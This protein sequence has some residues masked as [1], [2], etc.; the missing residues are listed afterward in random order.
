MTSIAL[1]NGERLVSAWAE[2][3]NGPGWSNR[4]VWYVVMKADQTYDMRAI[5][6]QDQTLRMSTLCNVSDVVT[7]DMTQAVASK[8]NEWE[9][10]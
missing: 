8:L 3:C 2:S 5:Q 10:A 1:N 6:P 9:K 4:P 7:R